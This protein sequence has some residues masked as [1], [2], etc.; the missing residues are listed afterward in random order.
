MSRTDRSLRL[1]KTHQADTLNIVN[2]DWTN[3]NLIEQCVVESV[4]GHDGYGYGMWASPPEDTAHGPNGPRNVVYH[5]D[6]SSQRAGLWMGGMNE[7]WLI[8]HNRF[9]VD[10][11]P[12]VFAKQLV[13]QRYE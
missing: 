1:G 11:G 3:E 5:C 9:V 6:I 13:P 10:R 12:G 4:R 8:L 7:N 2:V